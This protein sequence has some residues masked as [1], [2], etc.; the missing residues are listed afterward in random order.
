MKPEDFQ[1]SPTGRLVQILQ[2]ENPCF[3]FVRNPLP[4]VLELDTEIWCTLSDADRALDELAGLGR[5]MPNPNLLIRPFIRREAVLS[6]RIE[7]TQADITNL[8][9]YE[10]GQLTL[11]GIN[12]SPPESDVKEVL[13]YVRTLDKRWGKN[14]M[15]CYYQSL[16]INCQ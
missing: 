11:P 6:S 2:G 3:A 4:P 5:T 7:G 13:N 12:P 15:C 10:T 16:S 9:A 8:Y 14:L 1:N